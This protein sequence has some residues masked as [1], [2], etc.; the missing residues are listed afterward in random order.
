MK[1]LLKR[2]HYEIYE[3]LQLLFAYSPGTLG[4]FVRKLF[5]KLYLKKCGKNLLTGIGIRIQ[6][7]NSVSFGNNCGLNDYCW[8]AANYG[9]KIHFG[10]NVLVG[11]K[12]V[13]HSGNHVFK[14]KNKLIREQGFIFNEINIEDDVWIAANC[15]I[16]S[17]VK[18]GKGA[19]IAAGSVVNKNVE[20]YTVVA[21][22]PAKLISKR[23]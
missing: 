15:T 4:I 2:I 8:I 11:P 19:V 20:S 23:E 14:D 12:C 6:S 1:R 21:G 7:P 5:Y 13:F 22:I 3:T 18:I 17:G 9:G 16:L 10:D